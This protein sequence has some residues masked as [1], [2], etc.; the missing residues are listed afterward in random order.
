MADVSSLLLSLPIISMIASPVVV[1]F[2]SASWF[3]F[4]TSNVDDSDSDFTEH[5]SSSSSPIVITASSLIDPLQASLATFNTSRSLSS[6]AITTSFRAA[7]GVLQNSVVE[8]ALSLAMEMLE[9]DSSEAV[10]SKETLGLDGCCETED[11][12][13]VSSDNVDEPGLASV[14]SGGGVRTVLSVKLQVGADKRVRVSK[15]ESHISVSEDRD[16]K[17][18]DVNESDRDVVGNKES[19]HLDSGI[20]LLVQTSVLG[21][22]SSLGTS[23]NGADLGV[24][25]SVHIFGSCVG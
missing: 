22:S 6:I 10:D 17:D 14:V 1:S 4:I 2:I 13:V 25:V 15:S 12:E 3:L 18:A 20:S 7:T 11:S 23:Y 8:L 21:E 24:L 19:G 16:V 9:L 5:S